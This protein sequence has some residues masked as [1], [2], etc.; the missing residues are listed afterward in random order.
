M[1]IEVSLKYISIDGDDIGRK[2]T[3]FYLSNNIKQLKVFSS[4]L[5]LSTENISAYLTRLGFEIL[6]CA[7]D[8]VVASIDSE[9]SF[10]AIFKQIS[11][12]APKGVTF[13]AGVGRNLREAYIALMWAKSNGKNSLH[14]YYEL[15][16][17]K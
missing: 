10:S 15:D 8:G 16:L 2:I 4:S 1:I 12:L 6:F 14:H 11:E 13:S 17:T 5:K 9:V 7:A 3:S